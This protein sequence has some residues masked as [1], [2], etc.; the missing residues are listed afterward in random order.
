MFLKDLFPL[1]V[2]RLQ[3]SI[4]VPGRHALDRTDRSRKSHNQRS[5]RIS[6]HLRFGQAP[7]TY[8]SSERITPP[9][10]TCARATTFPLRRP[11]IKPILR[12]ISEDGA[13]TWHCGGLV[14]GHE[15][16]QCQCH[17][18]SARTFLHAFREGKYIERGGEDLCF[19]CEK[20][21]LDLCLCRFADSD[22]CHQ[23]PD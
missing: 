17:G 21:S 23:S 18:V 4:R 3:Q 5:I 12:Q 22:L 9:S 6:A 10:R 2:C 7:T 11:K 8:P 1:H 13:P 14:G 16:A 15:H 19:G 20:S